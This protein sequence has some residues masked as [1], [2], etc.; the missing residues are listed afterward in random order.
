M[1]IAFIVVAIGG[2]GSVFGSAVAAILVG[3][4]EAYMAYYYPPGSL[5]V[6]FII[7]SLVLLL[8]PSGLFGARR[9]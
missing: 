1:L 2:I 3:L 4:S 5:A 7:M 6:N 9:G 8:K